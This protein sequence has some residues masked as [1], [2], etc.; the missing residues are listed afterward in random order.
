MNFNEI[1]DQLKCAKSKN[2]NH[3]VKEPIQLNCEHSICKKCFFD[4]N[5]QTVN[6]AICGETSYVN[7]DIESQKIKHL[8]KSFLPQLFELIQKDTN[9]TLDNLKSKYF[10]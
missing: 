4:E 3:I 6:C 1:L 2:E 8:I 7:P 10:L 5:S 9:E